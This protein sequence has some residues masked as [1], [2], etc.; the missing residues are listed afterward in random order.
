MVPVDY[1]ATEVTHFNIAG[2]VASA[3]KLTIENTGDDQLTVTAVSANGDPVDHLS[4]GAQPSG[5][6][7]V[8]AATIDNGVASLVMNWAPAGSMP[9]QV[10]FEG[11]WSKESLEGN[12]MLRASDLGYIDTSF[13]PVTYDSV[14]LDYEDDAGTGANVTFDGAAVQVIT[15]SGLDGVDTKVLEVTKP[16]GETWAGVKLA[17][18]IAEAGSNLIAD[19]TAPIKVNVCSEKPDGDGA[20]TLKLEVLN[21]AQTE[22]L[23]AQLDN[24]WNEI[25]WVLSRLCRWTPWCCW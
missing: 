25:S 1:D 12:W 13:T 22:Q 19:S 16:G 24:G 20:I 11:L 6:A 18:F 10:S 14:T 15:A 17:K 9:E 7:R 2:E 23:F 8:S 4:I 5:A 21:G 3:I